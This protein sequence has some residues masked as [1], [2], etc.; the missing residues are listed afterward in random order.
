SERIVPLLVGRLIEC[1]LR[2]RDISIIFSTGIHRRP[3]EQE[4]RQ[5][6]SDSIFEAVKTVDHEP[7]DPGELTTLGTTSAGTPVEINCRLVEADHVIL[8]GSIG[9]HYFAGFTGGR[10]SAL[11]GLASTEAIKRNHLL[12]IDFDNG[13]AR[14]RSGV[15]TGRLFGNP[16][17]EDMEQ[18]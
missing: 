17:H 7:D 15:G 16:V 4:K 3:T 12:A 8:T 18:A 9:F 11:P 2:A 13:R 10:K 6:I 1:G 14:R 5:L